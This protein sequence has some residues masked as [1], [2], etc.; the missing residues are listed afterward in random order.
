MPQTLEA[1]R[2]GSRN[3]EEHLAKLLIESA[4]ASTIFPEK[5]C[6]HFESGTRLR[7]GSW[8]CNH[9]PSVGLVDENFSTISC[10]PDCLPVPKIYWIH[11]F[12]NPGFDIDREQG[13]TDAECGFDFQTKIQIPPSHESGDQKGCKNVIR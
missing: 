10:C 8:F 2:E 1:D 11:C 4:A 12:S 6:S 13:N 5:L 3:E 9:S 7:A